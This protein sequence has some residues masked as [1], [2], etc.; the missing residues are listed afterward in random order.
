MKY[1]E[2]RTSRR[3]SHDNEVF[4][5]ESVMQRK[6]TSKQRFVAH[7]QRFPVS[8]KRYRCWISPLIFFICVILV[9]HYMR[10]LPRVLLRRRNRQIKLI[11]PFPI[12][13]D[14]FLDK[15]H[16]IVKPIEKNG[17]TNNTEWEWHCYYSSQNYSTS[18]RVL[19]AQYS[20]HDPHY[21]SLLQSSSPVNRAYAKQWG[22]DY[23]TLV[24][25]G[26]DDHHV[27]PSIYF[28][29]RHS[30]YNKLELLRRG[31]ELAHQYDWIWIL[32]ADAVVHNFSI[33][34]PTILP[35]NASSVFLL[36]HRVKPN[37]PLQTYNIN[38]GVLVFNLHHPM[39]RQ[40]LSNW[41]RH[42]LN[43]IAANAQLRIIGNDQELEG[44]DQ[45][46]LH[47]ILRNMPDSSGLYTIPYFQDRV[48]KHLVRGNARI[49]DNHSQGRDNALKALAKDICRRHVPACNEINDKEPSQTMAC[50]V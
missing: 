22:M 48:V 18:P 46:I 11:L 15:F 20:G 17:A 27:M 33:S 13:G 37:D 34:F 9:R 8:F 43:R 26:L 4:G 21:S 36:A 16:V 29:E 32:D 7:L 40:V 45:V 2:T 50:S 14:D 39:T 42:S 25:T 28:L 1:R 49:W 35:P 24:G 3:R 12:D 44:D 47:R 19:L 38:N 41:T 23:V 6:L 5:F 31:L 10:V 30:S